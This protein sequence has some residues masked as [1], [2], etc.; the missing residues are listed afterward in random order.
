MGEEDKEMIKEFL[1]SEGTTSEE[2]DESLRNLAT[3]ASS[4]V[5]ARRWIPVAVFTL[6]PATAACFSMELFFMYVCY[7]T[8]EVCDLTVLYIAYCFFGGSVISFT[9]LFICARRPCVRSGAARPVQARAL[10]RTFGIMGICVAPVLATLI[11]AI[12][13]KTCTESDIDC[14]DTLAALFGSKGDDRLNTSR[15]FLAVFH[16]AAI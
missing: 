3:S 16:A 14:T 11:A 12:R 1:R 2:L 15:F 4:A 6:A 9:V 5:Q 10:N 13:K 8:R 7:L